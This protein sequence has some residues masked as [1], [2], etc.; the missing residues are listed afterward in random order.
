MSKPE[1]IGWEND[2]P[3]AEKRSS[4]YHSLFGT[5]RDAKTESEPLRE[6]EILVEEETETDQTKDRH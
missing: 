6:A 4:I 2:V 1:D 5:V 3:G